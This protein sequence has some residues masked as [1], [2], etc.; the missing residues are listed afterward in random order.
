MI[1]APAGL[2]SIGFGL[3]RHLSIAYALVVLGML[4]IAF[5]RHTVTADHGFASQAFVPFL[6]MGSTALDFHI[7]TVAFIVRGEAMGSPSVRTATMAFGMGTLSHALQI[8]RD[9]R[10]P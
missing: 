5:R 2:G 6:H 9:V 10:R 3:R 4:K 1:V 8:S 7:R